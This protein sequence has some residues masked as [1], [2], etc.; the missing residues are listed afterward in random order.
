MLKGADMLPGVAKDFEIIA[1][2]AKVIACED[3]ILDDKTGPLGF[4]LD[5]EWVDLSC[6][7]KAEMAARKPQ[8]ADILKAG[9]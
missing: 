7:L 9:A 2:V 5:D 1:S 4:E 6:E 3:D 8:Y